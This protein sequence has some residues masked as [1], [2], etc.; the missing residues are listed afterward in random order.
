MDELCGEASHQPRMLICDRGEQCPEQPW[1]RCPRTAAA[2]RM[3]YRT[4]ARGVQRRIKTQSKAFIRKM[5]AQ[6]GAVA[7]S[8][9]KPATGSSPSPVYLQA[10]GVAPVECK[11]REFSTLRGGG[12]ASSLCV[13]D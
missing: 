5:E 10:N 1:Q 8:L 12:A 3:R 9:R 6:Y 7:D 13:R 4:T 2:P 11:S